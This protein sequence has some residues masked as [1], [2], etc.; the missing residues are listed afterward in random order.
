MVQRDPEGLLRDQLSDSRGGS[1]PKKLIAE[2][3]LD[4]GCSLAAHL[5]H[6]RP[7]E[8][9]RS[10]DPIDMAIWR[11][12]A[13]HEPFGEVREDWRHASHMALQA[14]IHSRK[15]HDPRDYLPRFRAQAEEAPEVSP[16]VQAELFRIWL[17]AVPER[18]N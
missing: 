2:G 6:A 1:G 9:L 13:A 12:Y 14:T 5:G 7:L 15:R 17:G 8:M 4:F 18:G 10:M 16:E 3:G 11:A